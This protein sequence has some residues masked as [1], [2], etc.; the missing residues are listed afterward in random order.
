MFGKKKKNSRLFSLI[1]FPI[2]FALTL[3]FSMSGLK[4]SSFIGNLEKYN[5]FTFVEDYKGDVDYQFLRAFSYEDNDL[6]YAIHSSDTDTLFVFYNENSEVV[7]EID[8]DELI[9]EDFYIFTIENYNNEV[10]TLKVFKASKLINTLEFVYLKDYEDAK[11][12]NY[13]DRDFNDINLKSI[14]DTHELIENNLLK[15][16]ITYFAFGGAL[17][18]LVYIIAVIKKKKEGPDLESY[19]EMRQRIKEKKTKKI[20]LK[21]KKE[22]SKPLKILKYISINMLISLVVT[23]GIIIIIGTFVY[24]E[25]STEYLEYSELY[26]NEVNDEFNISLYIGISES[27]AS[28]SDYGLDTVVYTVVYD[29]TPDELL[30]G[31]FICDGEYF[32]R[33]FSDSGEIYGEHTDI[34]YRQIEI[35]RFEDCESADSFKLVLRNPNTAMIVFES[36]E[37]DLYKTADS[38][39]EAFDFE[40]DSNAV[41][42]LYIYLFNAS[43][44]ATLIRLGVKKLIKK[45]NQIE[46]R[47]Q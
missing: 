46:E 18:G 39:K 12:L 40:E 41:Y 25:S 29:K 37:Y 32:G 9:I 6:T 28:D 42:L 43:V 23:Y 21:E 10:L 45:D 38:A 8:S 3:Y 16:I 26:F 7:I 35:W 11:I 1:V 5:N 13:G 31:S 17:L 36:E 14:V 20:E 15:S 22:L 4:I 24:N 2:F 47:Y 33:S 34:Y 30:V 44:T 27:I 19:S